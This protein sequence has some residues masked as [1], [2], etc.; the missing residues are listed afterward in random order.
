MEYYRNLVDFYTLQSDVVKSEQCKIDCELYRKAFYNK[1]MWAIGMYDSSSK[2]QSGI[3]SGNLAEFGDF[4]QCI[5]IEV[6]IENGTAFRGKHVLVT[7]SGYIMF[8][9]FPFQIQHGLPMEQFP[10]LNYPRRPLPSHRWAICV[11]DSCNLDEIVSHLK[12]YMARDNFTSISEAIENTLDSQW[13]LRDYDWITI[14]VFIVIGVLLVVQTTYDTYLHYTKKKTKHWSLTAF[15]ALSNGRRLVAT[16][17]RPE[18]LPCLDGIRC[19][20][21]AWILL[22]HETESTMLTPSLIAAILCHI[23]I[24][25]LIGTGPMYQTSMKGLDINCRNNWW[26]SLLYVSNYVDTYKICVPQSW[27]LCVDTQLQWLSPLLLLPVVWWKKC[28]YYLFGILAIVGTGVVWYIAYDNKLIPNA[29]PSE[30]LALYHTATHCRITPWVMGHALAYFIYQNR[31]KKFNIPMWLATL[32][33][34]LALSL[35]A[36]ATFGMYP[37]GLPDYEYNRPYMSYYMAMS[38]LFYCLASSWIIFACIFNYGG[39]MNWFLSLPMW[40]VLSKLSYAMFLTHFA[41]QMAFHATIKTPTWFS[42]INLFYS[43]CGLTGTTLVVALIWTLSFE[44]PFM[45]IDAQVFRK[46]VSKSAPQN[47]MTLPTIAVPK[48]ESASSN[49]GNGSSL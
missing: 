46:N 29:E 45:V 36:Y 17:N 12:L 27:Y 15:S 38:T 7:L 43:F 8:T 2:M 9:P 49:N 4:N 34:V 47:Q 44:M 28:A 21:M 40:Q 20:C 42:K 14:S 18:L 11:P 39:I 23:S 37:I 10:Y 35:G 13:E 31:N 48:N 33:W 5:N 41:L 3:L 30:Y 22:G 32:L 24:I 1:E 6:N 16:S 19:I 25:R 26:Q